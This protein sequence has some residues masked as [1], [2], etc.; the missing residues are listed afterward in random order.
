[1][2]TPFSDIYARAIFRFAD[3]DFL[4]QTIR[5]REGVLEQ[6]LVSAKTDFGRICKFDLNDC[7]MSAKQF[8]ADLGDEEIEILASGIAFYW[9]SYKAMNSELLKNLLNSKDY[10]Y[11]SPENLLKE[12]QTLRKTIR[13]EFLSRMRKYSYNDNTIETLK[14]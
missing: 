5:D 12:V 10:Y 7:D 6:Y 2:A 1:M 3:Y 9:L 14:S 13:A 11:H 4:K 8:N